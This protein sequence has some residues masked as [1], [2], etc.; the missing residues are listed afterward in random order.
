MTDT[1]YL[2]YY[3]TKVSYYE[4]W[5]EYIHRTC[6]REVYDGRDSEGNAKYRT[7]TYDCSY[8]DYHPA[9][10]TMTNNVGNEIY[11]S[12]NRFN[13]IARKFNVHPVFVDMHR[14]YHTIDGAKYE[15][16][17]DGN[18]NKMYTLT[19]SHSYKNK[20]LRSRSIFNYSEVSDEVKKEHRLFDYS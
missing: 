16:R 20:I 13:I 8:V 12:E 6:T 1:E 11:I 9:R 10:W 14:H 19:S 18:R 2:G 4:P 17:F 3:V 5:N 15:H 7:E